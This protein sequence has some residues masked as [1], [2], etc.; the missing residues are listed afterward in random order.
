MIESGVEKLIAR[1][2]AHLF[3][4]DSIS[5]PKISQNDG[6]ESNHFFEDLQS[7][8]WQAMRFKPP[9][10]STSTI[11][12]RIEFRTLDLQITDFENSAYANFMILLTRAIL[13]SKLDL[14]LPISKV[15]K[16]FENAEKN[17]AVNKCKF[18]FRK[19][20]LTK[21]STEY[22]EMTLNE[23]MNGKDNEFPGLI[24]YVR[25]YLNKKKVEIN[26]NVYDRLDQ[27]LNL[28]SDRASGKCLTNAQWIRKE[29]RNHPDYKFD[30][31]VSDKMVY[32][33]IMKMNDLSTGVLYCQDLFGDR[34]NTI[35]HLMN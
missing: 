24:F 23:I 12:F 17:D 31:V 1:H 33:L 21:N 16:N 15:D 22:E 26:E 13:D 9:P 27:Y 2:I 3:I 5:P 7:T 4:R 20:I 6:E 30:S 19:D 34:P 11:G 29:V 8:N 25:V 28:I 10:T 35:K 18:W 14:L 32:D